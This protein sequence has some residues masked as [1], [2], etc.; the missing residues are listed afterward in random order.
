MSGGLDSGVLLAESLRTFR[1]VQP[2]YVRGGLLWEKDELAYL[3]RFLRAIRSPRLLPLVRIDVPVADL[4]AG[5]WSTTGKGSPGYHDGDASVYI[6]GRNIALL[7]KAA[8]FCALRRIPVLLSGI[9]SANPFPDGTPSFF[10]SIERA[11]AQGLAWPLRIRTPYR[12]LKK[13]Q[14]IRRGRDLPLRHTLSCL[15]PVRARHCGDCAKCWE[16]F[17]SFRRAGVPDRTVYAGGPAGGK[18]AVGPAP[19]RSRSTWSMTRVAPK[20]ATRPR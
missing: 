13:H 15:S 7:G 12:L 6:P 20:N 14:V 1:T 10:K 17:E 9:L 19:S 11:L 3:R 5:H 16:R 2:L 4:Y 8:T 18:G